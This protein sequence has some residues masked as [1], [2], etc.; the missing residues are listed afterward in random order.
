MMEIE[1]D[2]RRAEIY[3]FHLRASSISPVVLETLRFTTPILP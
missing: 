3:L 1:N 2:P